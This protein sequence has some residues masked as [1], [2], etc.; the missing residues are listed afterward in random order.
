MALVHGIKWRNFMLTRDSIETIVRQRNRRG[1]NLER[2]IKII[3]GYFGLGSQKVPTHQSIGD[4]FGVKLRERVRQII[5][6]KFINILGEEDKVTLNIIKNVIYQYPLVWVEELKKNLVE[7]GLTNSGLHN[8]GFV[9]LIK[10]FGICPDYDIYTTSFIEPSRLDF[11][12]GAPLLLVRK[13]V[14]GQFHEVFSL[15]RSVPGQHGIACLESVFKHE[16]LDESILPFFRKLLSHSDNCWTHE[17]ENGF[18]YV[19]EEQYNVMFNALGK[20][21]LVTRT[22]LVHILSDV[23]NRYIERRNLPYGSPTSEVIAEYL[24]E[25]IHTTLDGE[26]VDILMEGTS[27][28]QIE[29]DILRFYRESGETNI[30]Y[31]ELRSF[32]HELGYEKP[33][34]D[35]ALFRSAFLHV[36]RS[37]GRGNYRFI[38]LDSFTPLNLYEVILERLNKLDG[39]DFTSEERLRKEQR[40]LRD[41]LFLGK[42]VEHC[43]ICGKLYSVQSLVCAH[44]KKRAYCTEEERTD[45]H[46][47]MPLC[48]FGCDAMYEYQYL[49]VLNGEIFAN[50]EGLTEVE[51][52][53]VTQIVGR[54]LDSRWLEGKLVYFDRNFE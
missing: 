27:L 16:N 54:K 3:Q 49:G 33:Y 23:L 30:S 20:T 8:K 45:P 11:E 47:V 19:W 52:A 25:S 35:V 26:K 2:D 21:A 4:E 22:A 29:K 36:D 6:G 5:N 13:E 34:Y 1:G 42:D 38:L 44:K 50:T 46:I 28:N 53:Y 40:I 48:Q 9:N 43:A 18:W 24:K 15:I 37:A 39:T 7:K 17:N 32:L 41:W 12:R 14:K 31:S 51:R 10:T